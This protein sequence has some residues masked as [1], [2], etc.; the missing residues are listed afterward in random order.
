MY[1][2]NLFFIE[3]FIL[4]PQTTNPVTGLLK[5]LS[6]ISILQLPH[7]E[8]QKNLEAQM[9]LQPR[10]SRKFKLKFSPTEVGQFKEEFVLGLIGNAD[11]IFKIK[12]E[13]MAD[14]PKLN[15][16]P[17]SVFDRVRA[18]MFLYF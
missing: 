18:S 1:L 16:A 2:F 3:I 6:D 12:I 7:T 17:D 15:M 11:T 4:L 13:G 5:T 14:V 9:I 10:E 8:I